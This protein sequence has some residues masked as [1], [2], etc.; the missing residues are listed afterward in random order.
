MHW[1]VRRG[2]KI[3][4]Q[5]DPKKKGPDKLGGAKTVTDKSTKIAEEAGKIN[6]SI[7]DIRSTRRRED[8]SKL[9]DAELKARITRMNLEQQYSNL[10]GNQVSRGQSY[11][12]ST[13][14]IAG[15]VAAIGSSA[16]GIAVA[17]KQLKN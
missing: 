1:G 16:I 10:N 5:K 13:L 6:K 17:I 7:G 14:E 4:V 15:S 9:S 12:K 8:L 11:A 2:P 3:Q